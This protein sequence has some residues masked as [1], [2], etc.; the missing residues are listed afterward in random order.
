MT[1]ESQRQVGKLQELVDEIEDLSIPYTLN[2]D[3]L[4]APQAAL[5][6]QFAA[7]K[8]KLP[9]VMGGA[10]T[11]EAWSA[12]TGNEL[13]AIEKQLQRI[14][15]T[16]KTP[17]FIGEV[18]DPSHPM[19]PASSSRTQIW[20]VILFNLL[21]ISFLCWGICQHWDDAN[22]S[23][24][25]NRLADIE[26]KIEEAEADALVAAKSAAKSAAQGKQ[27][28]KKEESKKTE[29]SEKPE[30]A[31]KSENAEE[32]KEGN[33]SKE[34]NPTAE[35]LVAQT[36]L[37]SARREKE[38][39]IAAA[40]PKERTILLMVFLMGGLGGSIRMLSSIVKYVGNGMFTRNWLPFY[41][42]GALTGALVAP[43]I[44][45]MLRAGALTAPSTQTAAASLNL[46]SMYGFAALSGL[47]SK[48]A[49]DKL[50]EVFATVFPPKKKDKGGLDEKKK[51][52]A[53][54]PKSPPKQTDSEAKDD[55]KKDNKDKKE[56]K[57]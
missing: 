53:S 5:M 34:A 43:V 45:L 49:T 7:V 11:E 4:T 39:L 31:E 52:A 25:S 48:N 18:L 46:I 41:Y 22:N 57:A 20:C 42:L 28:E 2:P 35:L 14:V 29:Q 19:F 15:K 47:F 1:D 16:L 36:A 21:V 55:T 10:V 51:P 8:Q 27:A 30:D 13:S 32:T 9:I 26:A 17:A 37:R 24:D 33:V 56:E 12:V 3:E 40:V 38:K 44:Y 6:A 54:A 23:P 50:A